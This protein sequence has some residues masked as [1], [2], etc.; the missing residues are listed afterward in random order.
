VA[1]ELFD[2]L[3]SILTFGEGNSSALVSALYMVRRTSGV[4]P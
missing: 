2:N 3:T 4:I 1:V